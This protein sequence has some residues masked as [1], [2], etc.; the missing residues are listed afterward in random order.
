MEQSKE[1]LYRALAYNAV[2]KAWQRMTTPKMTAP[3][4]AIFSNASF[5]IGFRMPF[6]SKYQRS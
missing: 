6:N 5:M 3:N 2:K 1:S 4:K